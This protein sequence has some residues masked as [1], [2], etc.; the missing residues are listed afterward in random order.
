MISISVSGINHSSLVYVAGAE[1]QCTTIPAAAAATSCLLG[2]WLVCMCVC[3]RGREA[4]WLSIP[5]AT[6]S[7]S[8]RD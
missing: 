6:T 1:D 7:C 2:W 4:W 3:P 5:A 8:R